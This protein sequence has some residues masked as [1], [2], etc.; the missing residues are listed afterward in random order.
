MGPVAVLVLVKR[1][2]GRIG[3]QTQRFPD[4]QPAE[5]QHVDEQRPAR[6][7]V[8]AGNPPEDVEGV[9]TRDVRRVD[10]RDQPVGGPRGIGILRSSQPDALNEVGGVGEESSR[11]AHSSSVRSSRWTS[12]YVRCARW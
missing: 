12:V 1:Q 5:G 9:Q 4:A 7:L 11:P 3:G 2:A 10:R 6:A 8:V